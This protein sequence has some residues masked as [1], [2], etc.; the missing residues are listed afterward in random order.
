MKFNII[1]F[2]LL[3]LALSPVSFA[4]DSVFLDVRTPQ[5]FAEGHIQKALNLDFYN[6]N[7]EKEIKA[8]DKNKEYK[9]YCRS[10]N[11]SQKT[12]ELMKALGF[13]KIENIGGFSSLRSAF[14]TC[15]GLSC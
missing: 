11:R 12:Y 8:L 1:A 6:S 5:E 4:A 7:F 2:F 10:G 15:E 9:I 14:K 3:V 13:K